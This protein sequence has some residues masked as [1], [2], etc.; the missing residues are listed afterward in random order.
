MRN[1]AVTFT[2]MGPLASVTMGLAFLCAG[3]AQE[4]PQAWLTGG[5]LGL[6]TVGLQPWVG[7]SALSPVSCKAPTPLVLL[8]GGAGCGRPATVWSQDSG[9]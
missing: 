2:F 1:T 8:A 7:S 9:I 3:C 6:P 4:V 5:L